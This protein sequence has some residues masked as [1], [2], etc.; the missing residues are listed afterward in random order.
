MTIILIFKKLFSSFSDAK[1]YLYKQSPPLHPHSYN[2]VITHKGTHCLISVTSHQEHGPHR[3]VLLNSSPPFC[4]CAHTDP[5]S[6]IMEIVCY[7]YCIHYI[8]ILAHIYHHALY[9][10]RKRNIY[11]YITNYTSFL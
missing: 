3:H 8:N 6:P 7:I 5:C 9:S 11:I 4:G 2:H 1:A 10:Y